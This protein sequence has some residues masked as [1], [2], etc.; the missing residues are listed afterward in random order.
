[1]PY[2]NESLLDNNMEA[3]SGIQRMWEDESIHTELRNLSVNEPGVIT[4]QKE[5]SILACYK[6]YAKQAIKVPGSSKV[7]TEAELVKQILFLLQG[8]P[9]K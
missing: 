6:E 7:I 4:K 3:C 5:A 2:V 1:M 9:S 8:I